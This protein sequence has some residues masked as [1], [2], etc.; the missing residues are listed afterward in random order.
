M[1]DGSVTSSWGG[2]KNPND[3]HHIVERRRAAYKLTLLKKFSQSTRPS[4]IKETITDLLVVQGLYL[5]FVPVL[6]ALDLNHEG[7]RY[8]AHSV[9]KS[10]I[11]QMTRRSSED[12]YLHLI[13]FMEAKSVR[14][15]NRISPILK[16]LPFQ[17]EV[18]PEALLRAI[19][20]FKD[21]DGVI[22][23]RNS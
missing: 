19:Q 12:R 15:Q 4:K 22:D 14:I 1:P 16:A 3:L 18:G 11:F 13:A 23:R 9:I 8:Y 2:N 6:C 7:I 21:K 20:Y 17:G 10:E 5:D